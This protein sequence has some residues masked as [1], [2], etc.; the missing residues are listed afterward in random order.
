MSRKHLVAVL[1]SV[2]VLG[3][4]FGFT[5]VA[6]A[7]SPEPAP[8]A[9]PEPLTVTP[10]RGLAQKSVQVLTD[11]APRGRGEGGFAA[12]PNATIA[13]GIVVP[14]GDSDLLVVTFS[15]SSQI[16]G[17]TANE[18]DGLLVRVLVNGVPMA[19]AGPNIFVEGGGQNNGAVQNSATWC[20]RVG[21]GNYSVQAQWAVVDAGPTNTAVSA[22]VDD[23]ALHVEVS[24]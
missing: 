18:N 1:A 9:A 8:T 4:W 16:F 6:S 17:A 15:S 5:S 12:I 10:C 21:P 24:D 13:G 19:P 3:G 20:R 14:A 7:G 23:T 22:S 2:A 11:D